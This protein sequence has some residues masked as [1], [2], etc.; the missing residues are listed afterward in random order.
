[1]NFAKKLCF[2]CGITVKSIKYDPLKAFK[3]LV[4]QGNQGI[5]HF[6]QLDKVAGSW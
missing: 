1:M 2:I 5:S 3:M 4:I 6:M